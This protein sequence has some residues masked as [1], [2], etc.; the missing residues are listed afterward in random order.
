MSPNW[1]PLILVVFAAMGWRHAR[2]GLAR[3][4]QCAAAM[5][6]AWWVA[7]I[8]TR[9]AIRILRGFTVERGVVRM[10]GVGLS[11]PGAVLTVVLA[12]PWA[13]GAE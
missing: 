5:L 9:A 11:A 7:K 3:A 13:Q 4:G 8:Q 12:S 2:P 6:L 10:A 1:T